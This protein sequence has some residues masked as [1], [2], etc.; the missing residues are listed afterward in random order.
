MDRVGSSLDRS[1]LLAELLRLAGRGARLAHAELTPDQVRTLLGG[2]K[3]VPPFSE[4]I[5]QIPPAFLGRPDQVLSEYA[6]RFQKEPAALVQAAARLRQAR[7]A[8]TADARRTAAEHARL[9]LAALG[10]SKGSSSDTAAVNAAAD[11]W[12]VQYD[13]DGQWIDCDPALPGAAEGQTAA[14]AQ[15]TSAPGE[16]PEE[17]YWTVNVRVVI[18]RWSQG[19]L[20]EETVLDQ[21]LRTLDILLQDITLAHAPL[22]FPRNFR[23]SAADPA[24]R[25][26]SAVLDVHEWVP[27]LIVGGQRTG[28]ASI[29][30][31]GT[32]N[33]QP[34]QKP[35][36]GTGG[37]FGSL[38]G[39]DE[40]SSAGS[41]GVLT[42]EWIDYE[43]Q[44]PGSAAHR[45]RRES[46]DLVGPAARARGALP[47]P[48][49]N[50]AQRL[51]RGLTL[52][53]QTAI[54]VQVAQPSQQFLAHRLLARF[55]E[56]R[57]Q[58]LALAGPTPLSAGDARALIARLVPRSDPLWAYAAARFENSAVGGDVF[59]DAPAIATLRST[60]AVSPEQRVMG[61]D[62]FDIVSN[63]V[64]VREPSGRRSFSVRVE[65]GV[66][67]TIA[68]TAILKPSADA[69]NTADVFG[70]AA[71]QQIAPIVVRSPGDGWTGPSAVPADVLTRIRADLSDRHDVVL[72]ARSVTMGGMPRIGW[73]RVS[74]DD[75]TVVGVM[76][77]GLHQGLVER[78]VK[79]TLV[80]SIIGAIVLDW[81]D[82]HLPSNSR[83]LSALS[84]I[85]LY[86]GNALKN[87]AARQADR[88]GN[89]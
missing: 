7:E 76:D 9:L 60:T 71:A 85:C 42:A 4:R 5:P 82:E 1:L 43:I 15:T 3:R 41:G 18:E 51:E 21:R 67:D 81:L 63:Q 28:R 49:L 61:R 13:R 44:G 14:P 53:G 79:E 68:E 22:N 17:N 26:R 36:G 8:D 11:H 32:V 16:L 84:D 33:E 56:N 12:W 69:G 55:G 89:R 2:V 64:G 57:D 29:R 24:E 46:F 72:P 52:L 59:L 58:I 40:A 31:D 65:Q 23:V 39:G 88:E 6:Q 37:L 34:G 19:Q 83:I 25:L 74:I 30:D 62:V 20:A 50:E 75:G 80:P 27:T 86:L 78:F 87:E 47:A 38:A 10:E 35:Q 70:A 45:V 73:W 54:L 48:S 77:T 66:A